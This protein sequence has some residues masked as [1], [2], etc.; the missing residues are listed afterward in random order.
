MDAAVVDFTA[1][2][3]SVRAALDAV[4]AR[5]LLAGQKAVLIK[6]NLVNASPHP[7]TTPPDCC[8]AVISY[9]T[10]C[11]AA[12]IIIAEGT[13]DMS[14]ETGEV[15]EL[16][17]YGRLSRKT[18]VPLLD[19]NH[20]PLVKK[21]LPGRPVFPEMH[22]PAAAFTHF[23]ISVPVLKAHSLAGVTGTL[24]NMMGFAPPAYYGGGRGSWKKAVFHGRMQQSIADLNAY[25][26][27]DLSVLDASAGL[28]DYHL[29]GPECRPRV[30]KIVAGT[31]PGN[32]DRTAARLLGI[33]WN[34]IAHL[35]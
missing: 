2:E 4:G 21:A 10:S 27:P 22:L 14:R 23:I 34:A 33:D 5:D 20:A 16:L 12:E 30:G 9:V 26:T 13:G 35:C 11:C 32:V 6:P 7:V 25:R 24:K 1:Y 29:G 8:A 18:G 31:D 19:L 28:A 3:T 17:G 15:F